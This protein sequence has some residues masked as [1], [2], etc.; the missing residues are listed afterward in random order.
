MASNTAEALTLVVQG[1]RALMAAEQSGL[2]WG[3][4]SV[5]DPDDRGVWD[6]ECGLGFGEVDASRV[7]PVLRERFLTAPATVRPHES[8]G[9]RRRR[10]RC[11]RRNAEHGPV[12]VHRMM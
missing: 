11:N 5:R 12:V 3:H 6:E 9:V 8:A 10:H 2:V 7:V 1:S 4:A